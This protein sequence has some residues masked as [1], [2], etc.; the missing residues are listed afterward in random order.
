M[1]NRPTIQSSCTA[2]SIFLTARSTTEVCHYT[3]YGLSKSV[4]S[5]AFFPETGSSRADSGLCHFAD[6]LA[7]SP[8]I[9]AK[10]ASLMSPGN[11]TTSRP[12]PQ[13]EDARRASREILRSLHRCAGRLSS[14]TWQHETGVT[15]VL[16]ESGLEDGGGLRR[17]CHVPLAPQGR[18]AR[19]SIAPPIEISRRGAG[20]RSM[21]MY[22]QPVLCA[23]AKPMFSTTLA[24]LFNDSVKA[25]IAET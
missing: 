2:G 12:V 20:E 8:I 7:T 10:P 9:R 5:P 1:P 6:R 17:D 3:S 15:R 24:C 14:S 18:F 23:I 19:S 11:G 13:A 4:R 25:L 22:S 21:P 16:D